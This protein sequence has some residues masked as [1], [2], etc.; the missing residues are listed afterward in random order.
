MRRP[1]LCLCVCLFLIIALGMQ[2]FY[3]LPFGGD[4]P[5]W[6]EEKVC[7]CGQV[8]DKEYRENNGKEVLIIY[9]QSIYFSGE[10][11][12]SHQ[13]SIQNINDFSFHY[14]KINEF[15][16][17]IRC[18]INTGDDIPLGARVTVKG[19]WQAFSHATNPGE[20][21]LANYYAI[22]GVYG[23]LSDA[24][25][26]G[27]GKGYWFIRE[28]L[29]QLRQRLVNNLYTAF[30][31]KEA[32]ILAKMLLGENTGLDKE[33][34]ELYQENGIVH[35]LSISGLH[36]SM[37][38][39]GLYQL[40]RKCRFPMKSAAFLGGLLIVLYGFMT[41]F[42]V[43]SCR[44]IGMYLIHMLGEIW[45][46]TY[47]MLTAM[48]VL[49]VVLV[50]SN[51]R[52]VYHS[53]FLL[54]FSSVCG[55]GLLAPLLQQ[56]PGL[57]MEPLLHQSLG[58]RLVSNLRQLPGRWLVPILH[59]LPG[60]RLISNLQQLPGWLLVRPYDPRWLKGMKCLLVKLGS[61][62]GVSLSV[63][64][65]TLPIQLFFF[66]KIP[67]YSV[68]LN[69]LVIPFVSLVMIIGFVVILFPGLTFLCPL[70][71]LIFSWFEWL[72]HLFEELPGHTLLVGR[73]DMWKIIVYYAVLFVL[74]CCGKR[75]G[76]RVRLAVLAVLVF[77][78]V[79]TIDRPN[80]ITFL[81]VGQG[82]CICVQTQAGQCFL[83]DCGSSSKSNVGEKIL[84]PFLQYQGIDTVDGVFLSHPD[85][86]HTNGITALLQE[87][88]IYIRN[89]YLPN[90]AGETF[91]EYLPDVTG[92]SYLPEEVRETAEAYYA[93]E[94]AGTAEAYL[95]GDSA[96]SARTYLAGDSA[97]AARAYLAGDSAGATEAYLAGDSAGAARTYWGDESAGSAEAYLAQTTGKKVT[98]IFYI[99]AGMFLEFPGVKI[100]CLHPDEHFVGKDNAS[101][102]CYYLEIEDVGILLTG[103]VEGAGEDALLQSVQK[104]KDIS[105]SV[106]KVAHHGSRNSTSMEFLAEISP[107]VAIISCGRNNR[108]G[109]P[110]VETLGR[111]EQVG[112][113][114]FTTKERGAVSLELQDGQIR[115][116]CFIKEGN[117]P[118]K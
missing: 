62:F 116:K 101:S 74:V 111:L 31:P 10:G 43:S 95:A 91:A 25:I 27:T 86:D 78:L 22:E 67:I 35:I 117:Q 65:F 59:L 79:I 57:L 13:K 114:V 34:R 64:L 84:L 28:R 112:S 51:P 47:D 98:S 107:C 9:L 73:P 41:G 11:E 102:A 80:C 99:S 113:Y 58:R 82:E 21:D 71:S 90:V 66:Y 87:E 15:I 36:I 19:C 61:G 104:C 33:I 109:H 52:L 1:L 83:F 85:T 69:L 115:V 48:G 12:A 68:F 18:E 94:R 26:L 39:M 45:G 8:Y 77:F 7:L 105:V 118:G 24:E 29:Y 40:L 89:I 53:G 6:A 75:I 44:A 17:K 100:T 70:E 54:S 37:L 93:G 92:E 38:G 56:S 50:L 103:D 2:I 30:A 5:V 97:G 20:F 14:P 81:D 23:N 4:A 76:K 108:Y 72:C 110:H 63:T 49:C 46:K 55:V 60:R 106:L 32:S 96:G 42:G 88:D 16:G 3:P